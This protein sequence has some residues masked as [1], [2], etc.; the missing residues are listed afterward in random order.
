M[1]KIILSIGLLLGFNSYSQTETLIAYDYIESGNW[2]GSWINS[3]PTTGNYSNISVTSPNSTI[4]YGAGDNTFESDTYE[5]PNISV[6]P[7][8]QHYFWIELAAQNI[9]NFFGGGTGLDTNDYVLIQLST[10]GGLNYYDEIKITGNNDAI[11]SYNSGAFVSKT[12]NNSLFTYSP[13]GGGDRTSLGDGYSAVELFIPSGVSNISLRIQV[14]ANTT[15]E[16]WWLDNFELWE[17]EEDVPLPVELS[18]FTATPF[19]QYNYIE[20]VTQSEYNSSHFILEKSINGEDWEEIYNLPSSINSTSEISYNFKDVDLSNLVY[21]R[22]WQY[23][24]DGQSE[25]FGPIYVQRHDHKE[26]LKYLNLLGQ[27]INPLYFKGIYLIVYKDE[28]IV[29]VFK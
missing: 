9:T 26:I 1:K 16:D 7:L 5:L 6:D 10:D 22:L 2:N 13:A 12:S 29:K 24:I 18:S 17:I 21:Y 8:N 11:W 23:D 20:W 15:G 3:I 4:L 28:S 14:Q 25:L 19:T 27:E